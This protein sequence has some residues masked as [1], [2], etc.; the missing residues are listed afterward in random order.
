MIETPNLQ[1]EKYELTDAANLSDGYNNSMDKIDA[2]S[3]NMEG[4]FPLN[5][6][7]I[8]N[9]AVTEAKL[10]ADAVTS[11]K[12]ASGAI[13]TEHIQDSSITN[14]KLADDSVATANI[15][16]G[17]ITDVKIA[18]DSVVTDTILDAAVTTSKIADNSVTTE[19]LADG[20]VTMDVLPS[21]ITN[22]VANNKTL[23]E[24]HVN[25]FAELGVTDEQSATDLHTQIDNTY[26]AAMSNTQAITDLQNASV[27][28]N[29][30]EDGA[31]TI[32]KIAPSAIDSTPTAGSNNLISS[33]A[34]EAALSN[35][36]PTNM[37]F[38]V[39]NF[40][41]PLPDTY[42]V[43]NFV[44]FHNSD[45]T[46]IKPGC[47]VRVNNKTGDTKTYNSTQIPGTDSYGYMI[48]DVSA[49]FSN[50]GE[51]I[52]Y[53][54]TALVYKYN[55]SSGGVVIMET[56]SIAVG[57]DLNMYFLFSNGVKENLTLNDKERYYFFML[58]PLL[59]TN[60]LSQTPID[61]TTN[62]D[63]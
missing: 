59:T 2:Y 21:E 12:I 43:F 61:T 41:N 11:D 49:Y 10:A 33:G 16:D 48:G 42:D 37:V 63:N 34:V 35:F 26:Q 39:D 53:N 36:N 20:A 25:Y 24:E 31:V 4:R 3:A 17:S 56:V 15:Q 7:D 27:P 8:A 58:Q 40:S 47:Y 23:V 32:P 22:D 57:T 9:G 52:I 28:T 44:I 62:N 46:L 18:S 30:I 6:A 19:K 13:G 38:A 29:K 60:N 51:A 5:T 1:L 54:Y 45:N 55:A 50:T 14:A